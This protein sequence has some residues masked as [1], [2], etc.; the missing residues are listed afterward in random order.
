MWSM[1]LEAGEQ[2]CAQIAPGIRLRTC[3][4]AGDFPEAALRAASEKGAD[5]VSLGA[6]GRLGVPYGPAL[7]P[8][9]RAIWAGIGRPILLG[10]PHGVELLAG[11]E[12]VL[13][14]VR[15]RITT[16]TAHVRETA[17]GREGDRSLE[18]VV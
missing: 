13:V 14:A 15:H 6:V 12:S 18:K 9:T 7:D 11:E 16:G 4:V 10:S 5:V 17:G 3:L 8:T 2:T 1:I